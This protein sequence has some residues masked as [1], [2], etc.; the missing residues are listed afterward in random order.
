[1]SYITNPFFRGF[2]SRNLHYIEKEFDALT[3][4]ELMCKI[5]EHIEDQ[6][7]AID[8][9]YADILDL[10]TEFEQFKIQIN[11]ELASF[12]TEIENEV[13]VELENQYSR[14]VLLLAEYQTVVNSELA[15]LRADLEHEIEQIELRKCYCI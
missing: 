15:L 1:M 12:K 6:I 13:S 2:C 11:Q 7:K 5:L 3:D 8:E 14:I 4:Y 10:R 9:K